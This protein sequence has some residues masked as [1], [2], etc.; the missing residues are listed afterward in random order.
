MHY[1]F[2]RSISVFF[3]L[4]QYGSYSYAYITVSLAKQNMVTVLQSKGSPN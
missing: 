4:P 3:G 2:L 1:S